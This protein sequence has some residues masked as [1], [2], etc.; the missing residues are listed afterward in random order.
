MQKSK[1]PTGFEKAFH[2]KF[3]VFLTWRRERSGSRDVNK[4]VCLGTLI[5]E[6]LFS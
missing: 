4:S 2:E 5:P 6:D 1:S 3:G